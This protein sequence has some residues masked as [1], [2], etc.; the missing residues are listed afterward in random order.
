VSQPSPPRGAVSTAPQPSPPS[1]ANPPPPGPA[2]V[3]AAPIAASGQRQRSTPQ[4]L[5]MLSSGVILAS[6]I[7]GVVGALIFSYFA[8]SLSRAEASA[9][10]LIRVQKIQTD[11]LTADAT[12]TNAFLIGG[13]ER[14]AQRATYDKAINEASALIAESARAQAA[15]GAAL[16]AL[17]DETVRYAGT[18]EQARA[19][20]RQGLPVGAQY[21]RIA[22]TDLRTVALPI[23]ANL[24]EANT[25]RANKAME[26]RGLAVVFAIL[27]LAVLAGLLL[28]VVWVARTFKR[29]LN[30][31]LVAASVVVL[32]AF[33]GGTIGLATTSGRV[34]E[35]R[36][37][38]FTRLTQVSQARIEANNAKSNESLTLIARGSGAA[39]EQ[40]WQ[41]SAGQVQGNLDR[42]QNPDLSELWREYTKVHMSIRE[43]DDGG[44]WDQAVSQATGSGRNA[45]N[46][47]FAAFDTAATTF[48]E[49]M[50]GLTRDGLARPRIGLVIGA[51]LMFLA[52]IAAAV[53][54]RRG[55]A[56][57]LR[58]YR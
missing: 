6:L 4:R 18:V 24:V 14:P 25:T 34:S 50:A 57:R 41:R 42:S 35:L 49:E 40:V 38:S 3:P 26:V 12:A 9:R 39:F 33:V 11:L 37:G 1:V 10:Q 56:A 30:V 20:N 27:G 8:F 29:W 28:A 5:R 53:L 45:A 48:I 52:G 44:K 32:V 46:A 16:S 21:M 58:E 7:F 17:N 36:S 43:L 2:D 54:A 23:L 55:V 31:G 47:R 13:L 15:D 51:A 22:S 19:N